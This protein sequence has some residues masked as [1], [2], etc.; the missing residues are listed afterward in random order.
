MSAKK[1]FVIAAFALAL[2]AGSLVVYNIFFAQKTP[3]D[4]SSTSNGALPSNE[5][6]ITATPTISGGATIIPQK[7]VSPSSLKIKPIS[8][9]KIYGATIGVDGKTVKY[10]SRSSG[11]IFESDFDGVGLKEISSVTLQGLVKAI[12][13]PDKEMVIGVFS[14]NETIKKYYYNY[15]NNQTA[16]LNSN[17]GYIGWSPDS[18]KIAY[19]FTSAASEERTISIADPDGANWKNI[20]KTRLDDLIIEWPTKEK[21][22]LRTQVSGLAQGLLYVVDSASGDFTRILSDIYGLNVKW[23][24]KADKILYSKTSNYGKNPTLMLADEK[25]ALT[26]E[27]KLTSLVDKCV[28]GKDDRTIFCGLPQ[29]MTPNATWPDDYYKGLVALKDDFYKI[30]LETGEKTKILGSTNEFSY[31]AQDLFLSP[32]EDYLF[33]T[34]RSNGLLYSLKLQ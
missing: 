27:L 31:D 7:T 6:T 32:K 11:H 17:I 22:S 14:D 33:F 34:N 8:Q 15:A 21:I 10:F 5:E 18:K 2:V 26:K 24:P 19:Q 1:I 23:S 13:S 28:W 20:F 29:E 25:G 16:L 4:N 12:W 9:E 30:N 3:S